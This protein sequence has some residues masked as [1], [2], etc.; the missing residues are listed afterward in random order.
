MTVE[1]RTPRTRA[2]VGDQWV[3]GRVSSV[4]GGTTALVSGLRGLGGMNTLPVTINS[5]EWRAR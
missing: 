1:I 5:R 4:G 2:L 3:R